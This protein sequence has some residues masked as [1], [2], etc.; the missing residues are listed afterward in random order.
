M[1]GLQTPDDYRRQ[2]EIF[3]LA[4]DLPPD[5][6]VA[7]LAEACDGD[8]ELSD[9]V[10][11]LIARAANPGL[12]TD[13]V[14]FDGVLQQGRAAAPPQWIGPYKLKEKIGEG[15]M[16]IV[17]V[18]EQKEPVRRLVAMKVIKPGMDT[19]QVIARFEAERQALAL[20]D[21]PNIAR[22]FDGGTTVEGRPYFVMEL[23]RGRPFT[24]Y[25]DQVQVCVRSRVDLFMTTAIS[26]PPTYW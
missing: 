5:A 2:K 23:V 11:R 4:I 13:I 22:V 7:F 20:M 8:K 12:D 25:C 15:G 17:Y 18:A 1:P 21:H 10:R 19:R 3:N 24:D 9:R 6:Q 14:D 16:G 26:S